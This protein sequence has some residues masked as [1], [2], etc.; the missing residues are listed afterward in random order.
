M[1]YHTDIYKSSSAQKD[2][3]NTPYPTTL[4]LDNKR[5]PPW[6][7]VHSKKLVVCGLSKMISAH[8][9]FMNYSSIQKSK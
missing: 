8:K 4:V 2:S 7:G 6:D 3:P 1:I 5:A 9:I